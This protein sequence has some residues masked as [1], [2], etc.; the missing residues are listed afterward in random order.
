MFVKDKRDLKVL[1]VL[2][3]ELQ[4]RQ[5]PRAVALLAEVQAVMYGATLAAPPVAVPTPPTTGP[6]SLPVQQPG[7]GERQLPTPAA[8]PS[9]GVQPRPPSVAPVVPKQT[10]PPFID[11]PVDEAYKLLK[12]TPASTWESIEQT[13]RLLVQQAHPSRVTLLSA[14]KCAQARAEAARVNGAYLSL[15]VARCSSRGG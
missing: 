3:H 13:R 9:A 2:E 8:Q 6:L 1:K 10:A 11:T 12:A 5:V 14:E 15:A 4:Y 7:P